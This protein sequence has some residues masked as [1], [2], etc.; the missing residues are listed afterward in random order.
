LAIEL[1]L[2]HPFHDRVKL[3]TPVPRVG[4]TG[5]SDAPEASGSG[6]AKTPDTVGAL[7]L[8]GSRDPVGALVLFAFGAASC[9]L[10]AP[11]DTPSASAI[12][13][14]LISWACNYSVT[15]DLCIFSRFVR[16]FSFGGFCGESDARASIIVF[17][18]AGTV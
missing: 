15:S 13:R 4:V 12:G 17:G 18:S 6:D 11:R 16:S 5:Y 7:V 9:R 8:F 14:S 1:A 2:E 10:T 3:G